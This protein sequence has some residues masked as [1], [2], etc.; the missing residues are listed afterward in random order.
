MILKYRWIV[1][2]IVLTF[3]VIG[4]SG[5][6]GYSTLIQSGSLRVD[7]VVII[8]KGSGIDFISRLL[9]RKGI[10]K[11]TTVFKIAVLVLGLEKV[12]QAGEYSIPKGSSPID[13]LKILRSGK[14]VVRRFLAVEGLHTSE[15]LKR[16]RETDGLIGKVT[17]FTKEGELLPETYHFSFGD[18]RNDL[19]KRMKVSMKNTLHNL[20]SFRKPGLPLATME[21]AIILASIVEKET[22]LTGERPRIARVFINRLNLGMR[23]Q[24]DPTVIYGLTKGLYKFRRPLSKKDLKKASTYNTYL[25]EGLPPGPIAN[26]GRASIEAVLNPTDGEELY[27]VADG[28]GGHAFSTNLKEHNKNVTKWRKLEAEQ[29]K[30][31]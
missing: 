21:E 24:S 27:F 2:L 10:I 14:T 13:I 12:I 19:V 3:L 20:W 30:K 22:G 7:T 15:I 6:W 9:S 1:V 17:E 11:Q 29:K 4:V 18:S 16:V 8:P 23:L 28:K 31:Q 26:P 5:F 25:N